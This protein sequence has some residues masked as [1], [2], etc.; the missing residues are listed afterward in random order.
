MAVREVILG[1]PEG[2]DAMVSTSGLVI[3]SEKRPCMASSANGHM[4]GGGGGGGGG[5][6]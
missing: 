1:F 6:S 4:L 2:F 3:P 5:G